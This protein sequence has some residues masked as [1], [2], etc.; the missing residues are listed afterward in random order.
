MV[1]SASR[2]ALNALTMQEAHADPI[3]DLPAAGACTDGVDDP[4]D[5]VPGTIGRDRFGQCL[6]AS[7]AAVADCATFDFAGTWP[8][9][10][11]VVS[12]SRMGSC[13]E[14]VTSVSW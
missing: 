11:A 7:S 5:V 10:G 6:H 13:R 1:V 8:G 14:R 3:L 9:A 4:E 2:L 12:L